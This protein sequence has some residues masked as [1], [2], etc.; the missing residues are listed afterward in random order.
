MAK[1]NY[2]QPN[3]TPPPWTDEEDAK[4]KELWPV[5]T[6]SLRDIRKVL[7]RSEDQVSRRAKFLDL[8][9]RG[10]WRKGHQYMKREEPVAKPAPPVRLDPDKRTL[11][12]LPSEIVRMTTEEFNLASSLGMIRHDLWPVAT[13]ATGTN[14]ICAGSL[15]AISPE[16]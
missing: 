4:L 14:R 2:Q 7:G 8:P 15:H 13:V 3:N 11:P 12:Y 5:V 6:M 16:D 10:T 9:L 1:G